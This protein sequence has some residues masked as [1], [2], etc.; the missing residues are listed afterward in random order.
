MHLFPVNSLNIGVC[1]SSQTFKVFAQTQ[2]AQ[3]LHERSRKN[4]SLMRILSPAFAYSSTAA[5]TMLIQEH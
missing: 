4:C 1:L 5:V 2:F 3:V